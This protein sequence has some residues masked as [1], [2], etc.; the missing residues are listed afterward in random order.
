MN[1]HFDND[2]PFVVELK[3]F[4]KTLEKEPCEGSQVPWNKGKKGVQKAWNRG[5]KTGPMK[6]EQRDKLSKSLTGRT[7][8]EEHK[9]KIGAANAISKLG[10]IPWNKGKKK[11]QG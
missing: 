11:D 3:A 2:D 9:K 1:H 7:L 5:I 10:S 8:S 6:P 4:V